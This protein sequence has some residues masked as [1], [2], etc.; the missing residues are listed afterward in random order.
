[1]KS[2]NCQ[3]E[4]P[5]P[6][7]HCLD[8]IAAKPLVDQPPESPPLPPFP[9]NRYKIEKLIGKGGRK[10]VYLA[11]DMLLGRDVAFALSKALGLESVIRSRIIREAQIMGRLGSHPNIVTI[12]DLGELDDQPY[13]IMELINGGEA[14]G[15]IESAPDN[16]LPTE[17]VIHIAESVCRGLAF[18]HKNGVIHRDLNPSNIW[19]TEEGVVKIGDF[20]FARI[21]GHSR[22]TQPD[23]MV[24]TIAYLPPEEAYGGELTVQ[25]DLYSLGATMYEMVT[26][27]PPFVGDTLS[28]IDQ[29]IST[30]PV[31]PS[32]HR[33]DLQ[34]ACESLILSLL[35]K[36]PGRRP[37][38][39]KAVL[40]S[41]RMDTSPYLLTSG[42][43]R[44]QTSGI[45]SLPYP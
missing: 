20:G 18:A 30:V 22:L 23:R 35:E 5:E 17:K 1:M 40:E 25:S 16:R 26:G 3:S 31:P 2:P 19:L 28:V 37:E 4:K 34:P 6:D 10:H 15:L 24:G 9:H 38:S 8:T 42:Q 43:Q 27:R 39:A 44:I 32:W 41:L 13:I 29:H 21:D 11:H 12:F 45:K 14:A 33:P 36:D 7:K